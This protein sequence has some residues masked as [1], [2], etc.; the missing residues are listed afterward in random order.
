MPTANATDEEANMKFKPNLD[1]LEKPEDDHNMTA[2]SVGN[3][4]FSVNKSNPV[5]QHNTQNDERMAKKAEKK[6]KK[7]RDNRFV[8]GLRDEMEE[9][10]EQVDYGTATGS[11]KVRDMM[12]SEEKMEM[13]HMRRHIKTKKELRMERK[14]I[15]EY[16]KE[17]VEDDDAKK[18]FM[19]EI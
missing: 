11:K 17:E 3:E 19:R 14:K 2:V 12:E 9:R 18:F 16:E 1:L 10:P 6:K 15:R 8:Q 13:Q 4:K 5:F 7:L